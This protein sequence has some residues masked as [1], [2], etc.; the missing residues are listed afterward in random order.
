MDAKKY[1]QIIEN[2]C[3]YSNERTFVNTWINNSFDYKIQLKRI[4]HYAS[5]GI[6]FEGKKL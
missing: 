2:L 4:R 1:T 3:Y 5:Q 6:I